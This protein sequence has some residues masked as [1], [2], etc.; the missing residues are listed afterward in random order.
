M[1]DGDAAGVGE[2]LEVCQLVGRLRAEQG[3]RNKQDLA[4][5]VGIGMLHGLRQLGA[6]PHTYR[7]IECERQ[8]GHV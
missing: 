8:E 3:G 4:D 1:S 5:D 6:R 2:L 7:Q